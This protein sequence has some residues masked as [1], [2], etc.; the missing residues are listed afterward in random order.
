MSEETVKPIFRPDAPSAPRGRQADRL[1]ALLA[2]FGAALSIVGAIWFFFGFAENDT[3]PEHLV[4]AFV[5][6]TLLF[7]FAV[8]PFVILAKFARQAFRHGTTRTHLLWSLFLMIP[9]V[10]LGSLAVSYTPLPS[11][12]GFLITGLAGLL[13]IWALVSLVLD[14]NVSAANTLKSQQNEMREPPE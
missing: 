14:W 10:I 3:R 13:T 12:C 11:W 8:I 4:S 5:L 6:T 1:A 7:A 2:G 9:W